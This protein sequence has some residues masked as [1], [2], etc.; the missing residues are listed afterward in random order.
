MKKSLGMVIIRY[1]SGKEILPLVKQLDKLIQSTSQLLLSLYIVNNGPGDFS[2]KYRSSSPNF[3]YQ[4]I[5]DPYN[6]GFAAGINLGLETAY[7]QSFDYYIIANT[8]IIID[9]P[10]FFDKLLKPFDNDKNIGLISP[11]IYFAPGYEFHK[12]RYTQ[13][14]QGKVIWYAGGVIDW[15][16]VYAFHKGV[17]QIDTGQFDKLQPTGFATGC[18]MALTKKALTQTR[19]FDARYFLYFE[20]NDLSQRVKKAGLKVVYNPQAYLYHKNAQSTKGPGS[21]LHFYYQ[22]RNRLIFGFTYAP[23][24]TKLALIKNVVLPYLFAN[25]KRKIVVDAIDLLTK[26]PA[27]AK[28]AD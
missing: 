15:Q 16:N 19:G 1:G 26:Q 4:I 9:Q 18:F 23:A 27:Y 25:K 10:E 21:S 17:D 7:K 3:S 28:I 8:D 2:L 24:K 12:N 20:D 5:G 13:D 22:E 11:K 6:R 14:Q